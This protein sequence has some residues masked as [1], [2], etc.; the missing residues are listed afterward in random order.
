MI[1][2][3]RSQLKSWLENTC[4]PRNVVIDLDNM[5]NEFE[6]II[7]PFLEQNRQHFE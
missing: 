5:K 3:F 2:I 7:K 1:K 4:I 6:D